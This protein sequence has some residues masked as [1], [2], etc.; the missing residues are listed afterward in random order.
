[1]KKIK[2]ELYGEGKVSVEREVPDMLY[3]WLVEV[4]EEINDVYNPNKE[5][6]SPDMYIEE[7]E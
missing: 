5:Y 2:I 1:M 4:A 3:N 6:Y 7:I